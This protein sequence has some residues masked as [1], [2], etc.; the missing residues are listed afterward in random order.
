MNEYDL[1]VLEALGTAHEEHKELADLLE[2]YQDLYTAQFD[3]KSRIPAPQVNDDLTMRRR[4]EQGIPQLSF[5]QLCLEP[6][7]FASVVERLAAVFLRHNPTWDAQGSDWNPEEL[8]ALARDAYQ[9]WETPA[10]LWPDRPH[11]D[12]AEIDGLA[13]IV[14]TFALGPYLQR[15]AEAIMPRLDMSNWIRRYCP[16]CGG[17]PNLALLDAD[18]A[19]RRLMCSRCASLWSYVRIGCPFCG[20]KEKQ[21][22]YPSDTGLYRL[23]VC[24]HCRRYLKTID[25]DKAKSPIQPMV[26]RLLTV[27]MDLTAQQE[28]WGGLH[29]KL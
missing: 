18:T 24:P 11:W 7:A 16:V 26:E 22:Y 5:E 25:L 8:T 10:A 23:Y 9:I 6:A 12:R 15:A 20:V 14:V 1:Q 27:N 4:L 17:E 13:A 28:G 2:F 19:T 21:T 3:I 29:F